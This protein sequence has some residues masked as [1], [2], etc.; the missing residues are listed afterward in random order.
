VVG[1]IYVG[2]VSGTLMN[3]APAYGILV[4]LDQRDAVLLAAAI[5]LGSLL[6][7][8]PMG[9]LADRLDARVIMLGSASVVTVATGLL[10]GL[11]SVPWLDPGRWQLLMFAL[12]G[13]AAIPLYTVA[14]VHAYHRMGP[15]A[16]VGL[17]AGLLLLWGLGSAIGPLTATGFM[18]LFGPHGLLIYLVLLSGGL[19]PYLAIRLRRKPSPARAER[20]AMPPLPDVAPGGKR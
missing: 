9:F 14:V 17:S 7:Q 16:A 10:L 20:P 13:G 19:V 3:I 5:Q 8:W 15:E 6:L 4:G 18:Q 1:C 11:P 2:L 12:V